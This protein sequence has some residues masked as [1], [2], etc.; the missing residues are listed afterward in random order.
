LTMIIH[1]DKMSLADCD[2]IS[3][4][5]IPHAPDTIAGMGRLCHT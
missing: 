1:L 2:T 3:G 4:A 5:V